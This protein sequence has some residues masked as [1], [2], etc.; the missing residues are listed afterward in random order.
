MRDCRGEGLLRLNDDTARAFQISRFY[1]S[2]LQG[3]SCSF[4][5]MLSRAAL[6]ASLGQRESSRRSPL[7]TTRASA[8]CAR[9]AHAHA[10]SLDA[11]FAHLSP[12]P[13]HYA[14]SFSRCAFTAFPRA[15][16]RRR[17]LILRCLVMRERAS[18]RHELGLPPRLH[19][20]EHEH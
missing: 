12:S 14:A 3:I 2:P 15:F 11:T 18:S 5:L 13:P 20:I 4:E 7:R 19:C 6:T 1:R 10:L 8:R 9:H 16:I 17:A